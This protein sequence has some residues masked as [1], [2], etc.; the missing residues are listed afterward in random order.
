MWII[1]RMHGGLRRTCATLMS[2][3]L[4]VLFISTSASAA[5]GSSFRLT[6]RSGPVGTVVRYSGVLDRETARINSRIATG[7]IAHGLVGGPA[8]EPQ[9]CPVDVYLLHDHVGL[10]RKTRR[11]TGSFVIGN[12]G[13]CPQHDGTFAVRPGKYDFYFGCEACFV[14]SFIVTPSSLAFTGSTATPLM[15]LGVGLLAAGCC[16]LILASARRPDPAGDLSV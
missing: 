1:R 11:V 13:S 8:V 12:T 2:A 7:S 5:D 14:A 6:V 4:A 15:I 9:G 16:L 10:D 3:L